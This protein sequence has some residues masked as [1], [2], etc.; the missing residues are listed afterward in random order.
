MWYET[1]YSVSCD[2]C[3]KNSTAGTA[4]TNQ[5]CLTSTNSWRRCRVRW[6]SELR[7]GDHPPMD[8]DAAHASSQAVVLVTAYLRLRIEQEARIQSMDVII[9]NGESANAARCILSAGADSHLTNCVPRP[10]GC[11]RKPK[12]RPKIA[13]DDN[14]TRPRGP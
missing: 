14:D 3:G 10:C 11:G 1:R 13:I 5:G 6:R 8:R 12:P 2:T 7:R 9:F 4:S